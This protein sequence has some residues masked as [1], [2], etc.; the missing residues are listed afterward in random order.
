M[1][2]VRLPFEGRAD[3]DT[4]GAVDR[5]GTGFC[6]DLAAL[7]RAGSH[8]GAIAEMLDASTSVTAGAT[9]QVIAAHPGWVSASAL[10]T[11]AQAWVARLKSARENLE[12]IS[13]KLK[14][15]AS[16]YDL[17]EQDATAKINRVIGELGG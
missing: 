1:R 11:C 5:V 8:T 13:S 6:V 14:D 4:Q 2:P 16:A 12:T 15:T 9:P 3:R 17:A 10:H 7:R